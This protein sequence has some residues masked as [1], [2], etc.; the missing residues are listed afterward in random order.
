MYKIKE[1]IDI[2]GTIKKTIKHYPLMK[3]AKELICDPTARKI[4][5]RE[6]PLVPVR[7]I[8]EALKTQ[9]LIAKGSQY[10]PPKEILDLMEYVETHETTENLI[11]YQG[12]SAFARAI[13]GRT[14]DIQSLGITDDPTAPSQSHTINDFCDTASYIFAEEGRVADPFTRGKVC[15]YSFYAGLPTANFTWAKV[16][17]IDKNN[18]LITEAVD[19]T[20][21][22]STEQIYIEYEVSL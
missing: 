15:V 17:L 12:E 3:R 19:T 1:K 13:I 18:I 9:T 21:K 2:K 4:L 16:G 6:F 7:V 11:T 14:L 20:S 8:N 10:E 5:M 22:T